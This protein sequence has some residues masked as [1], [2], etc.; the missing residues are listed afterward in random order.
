MSGN[1]RRAT[2]LNRH[3]RRKTCRVLIDYLCE[4]SPNVC[5]E[6]LQ[7]QRGAYQSHLVSSKPLSTKT[8]QSTFK[9]TK[10]NISGWISTS[11]IIENQ[12][13]TTKKT[14]NKKRGLCASQG[15]SIKSLELDLTINLLFLFAIQL[16]TCNANVRPVVLQYNL[17]LLSSNSQLA[18]LPYVSR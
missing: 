4:K 14:K 3:P 11:L 2:K 8:F 9:W 5:E 17:C 16:K 1:S 10:W 15:P 6:F 7:K 18:P 13:F 12:E